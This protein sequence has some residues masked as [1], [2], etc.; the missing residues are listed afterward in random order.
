MIAGVHDRLQADG[1]PGEVLADRP[2]EK[3]VPVIDADFGHI[4]WIIA[5]HHILP[6]VGCQGRIEIAEA[7]KA[8]AIAL[9]ATHFCDGE[10]Q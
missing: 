3:R 5:D 6:H 7:L 1:V 10:E 4:A 2:A 9:H 8:N